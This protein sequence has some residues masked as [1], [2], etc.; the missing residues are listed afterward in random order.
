[1]DHGILI[2]LTA[3]IV[4]SHVANNH[5][6]IGE[7]RSLVENV[8]AALA[9]LE[10]PAD[11]TP[12]AMTPA[13]SIRSSVKP[14]SITCL[15]CGK[16]QKTMKRHLSVA[17]GLSPAEYRSGFGLADGYPMTAPAYAETRRTLAKKIGLGRKPK[18]AEVEAV[19]AKPLV[20]KS[21][22][23]EPA[24]A[25]SAPAKATRAKA[26][27]AISS[28][29]A[30]SAKAAPAKTAKA[31][32]AKSPQSRPRKRKAKSSANPRPDPDVR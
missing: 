11:I 18:S 16:K 25:K 27:L 9:Q 20:T 7:M 13:V 1:M 30:A 32:P 5:V 31:N 21:A 22:P 15:I 19:P 3:E 10:K 8:H 6:G 2:N 14:D 12:E 17:H 29:K 26:A 4:A 24:S 28:P 23:A